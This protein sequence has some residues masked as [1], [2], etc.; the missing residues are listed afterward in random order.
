M[1][2]PILSFMIVFTLSS[3]SHESHLKKVGIKDEDLFMSLDDSVTRYESASEVPKEISEI[4]NTILKPNQLRIPAMQST[5]VD[6]LALESL[7]YRYGKKSSTPITLNSIY[8]GFTNKGITIQAFNKI[9]AEWPKVSTDLHII[10]FKRHVEKI[11]NG[12]LCMEN[13]NGKKRNRS[14]KLLE[15]THNHYIFL[16]KARSKNDL[17]F[18]GKLLNY[19]ALNPIAAL[20]SKISPLSNFLN[21][22]EAVIASYKNKMNLRSSTSFLKFLKE[23]R[24]SIKLIDAI[25]TFSGKISFKVKLVIN[26]YNGDKKEVETIVMQKFSKNQIKFLSSSDEIIT[27]DITIKSLEDLDKLGRVLHQ[28]LN[29]ASITI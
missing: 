2:I 27:Y 25:T 15:E 21:V 6:K 29:K 3:C 16:F 20:P 18:L 24:V 9:A 10:I 26:D 5:S 14:L 8:E 17:D 28:D 19:S 12:R 7:E 1:R 4:L 22:P 23:G 11:K 13:L